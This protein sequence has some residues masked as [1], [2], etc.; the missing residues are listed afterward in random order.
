M[1]K[2]PFEIEAAVTDDLPTD[3]VSVQYKVNGI[4]DSNKQNVRTFDAGQYVV[5]A[6][7]TDAA[8]NSTESAEVTFQVDG[9]APKVTKLSSQSDGEYYR[10]KQTF[11]YQ[12][13]DDCLNGGKTTLAVKRTIDGNSTLDSK[14]VSLSDTENTVTNLQ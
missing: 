13:D 2:A 4:S 3:M 12:V 1:Y 6:I 7:A 11:Q 14:T 9:A 5:S 10:S 8:G